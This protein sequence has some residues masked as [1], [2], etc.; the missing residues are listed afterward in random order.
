MFNWCHDTDYKVR[1]FVTIMRMQTT[2][3]E[4]QYRVS[5]FPLIVTLSLWLPIEGVD[6]TDPN[7]TYF[8]FQY[9]EELAS[10]IA[11]YNRGELRVEPRSFYYASRDAKARLYNDT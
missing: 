9:S 1:I 5:D 2:D 3:L 4:N 7:R 11:E 10:L 6:R 8:L